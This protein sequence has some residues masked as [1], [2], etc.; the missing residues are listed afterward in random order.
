MGP[1]GAIRAVIVRPEPLRIRIDESSSDLKIEIIGRW[2]WYHRLAAALPVL[3]TGTVFLFFLFSLIYAVTWLLF[4]TPP[5]VNQPDN[6]NPWGAVLVLS[7][8]AVFMVGLPFLLLRIAWWRFIAVLMQSELIQLGASQWAITRN[9]GLWK[10]SRHFQS[11]DVS[12]FQQAS[13]NGQHPSRNPLRPF[14]D[15]P[16]PIAFRNKRS[17][18]VVGTGAAEAEARLIAVA[19]RRR[20]PERVAASVSTEKKPARPSDRAG[21]TVERAAQS[22]NITI[23]VRRSWR[24]RLEL[25]YNVVFSIFWI[26]LVLYAANSIYANENRPNSGV[27]FFGAFVLVGV[28]LGLASLRELWWQFTGKE[29]VHVSA[30]G[31]RI[32]NPSLWRSRPHEFL[33]EHIYG[34]RHAPR[35]FYFNRTGLIRRPGN[36]GAIAFDYGARTY[37]FGDHL[38]QADADDILRLIAKQFP[39]TGRN[40][41]NDPVV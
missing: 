7:I 16:G 21:W 24:T 30:R 36:F 4:F 27:V 17:R 28:F 29:I 23:P 38:S 10:S 32:Q 40:S 2:R 15:E 41:V 6:I 39:Q 20:F 3:W 31:I 9:Y 5:A 11:G 12:A 26:G 1:E 19:V 37:R 8:I 18:V 14:L 35:N 34:L 22:L 25:I 33:A 13:T